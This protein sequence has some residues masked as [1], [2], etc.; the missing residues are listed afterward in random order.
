MTR[1]PAGWKTVAM[2]ALAAFGVGVAVGSLFLP[3]VW[4]TPCWEVRDDLQGA[5]DTLSATFGGG[6]EGAAALATLREASQDRP[7]CFAP[8]EH[9]M[10]QA[11]PSDG[12]T[13]FATEVPTS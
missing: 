11:E 2:S 4:R 12:G 5:R 13:D 7:D 8:W 10:F 3:D 9:D 6:E 1:T